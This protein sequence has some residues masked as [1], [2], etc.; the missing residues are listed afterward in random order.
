MAQ[1]GH[2]AAMVA[3]AKCGELAAK[4]VVAVA[5]GWPQRQGILARQNFCNRVS[6]GRV[7][8][9]LAGLAGAQRGVQ[10]IED[11][12]LA[13]IERFGSLALFLKI[14]QDF[15]GVRSGDVA[16]R[17]NGAIAHSLLRQPVANGVDRRGAAKRTS[18]TVPPL[19]SMP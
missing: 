19:K 16:D 9:L 3:V 15:V 8:I 2:D 17:N 5:C 13:G 12:R 11:R 7:E 1:V 4:L 14:D 10:G 6:P 18:T